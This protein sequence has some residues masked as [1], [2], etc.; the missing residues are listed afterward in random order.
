MSDLSHNFAG[1]KLA[2][3]GEEI[4]YCVALVGNREPTPEEIEYG[5]TLEAMAGEI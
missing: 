1:W 5:K 2:N 4:P 3:I